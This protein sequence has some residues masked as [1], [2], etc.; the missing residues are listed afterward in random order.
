[1]KDFLTSRSVVFFDVVICG[2]FLLMFTL[3]GWFT[4]GPKYLSVGGSALNPWW[5][6][7]LLAVGSVLIWRLIVLAGE[8]CFRKEY[9]ECYCWL[10]KNRG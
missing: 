10:K 8:A 5:V 1:M 3:V 2:V 6:L 4:F 9:P 7:G